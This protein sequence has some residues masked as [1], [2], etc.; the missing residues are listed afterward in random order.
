MSSLRLSRRERIMREIERRMRTMSEGQPTDDP[1]G[2]T[3]AVI[4]R[5]SD[6][7]GIHATARHGLAILD[8][9]ERKSAKINQ[10]NVFLRVSLEFRSWV[11]QEESPST[12]GNQV[13]ADV[14]RRMREDLHLTEPDDG[15]LAELDRQ[16]SEN[17]VEVG[18][19]L[20]IDGFADRQITGAVTF[21][22]LYKHGIDD[23]RELVSPL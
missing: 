5:G 13:M 3:F 23:P 6:L 18:N 2:T 14:Q 16:L 9:E 7:E 22:V 8:V 19:E 1:Y 15:E 12:V 4:T 20:F 17:V 21:E 11:D 10:M